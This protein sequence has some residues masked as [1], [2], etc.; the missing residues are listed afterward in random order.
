MENS[1][2]LELV[3][4]IDRLT[5]GKEPDEQ[6]IVEL[7]A[8]I[9]NSSLDNPANVPVWLVDLFDALVYKRAVPSTKQTE[10]TGNGGFPYL[11]LDQLADV[12]DMDY[13][14]GGEYFVIQFPN[15]DLEA[16]VS[17]KEN[18]YSVRLIE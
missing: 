12:V 14:E 3:R 10:P 5:S 6:R 9:E 8:V 4:E 15:I 16:I 2:L 13:I 17:L 18:N 7:N 11:F 1:R